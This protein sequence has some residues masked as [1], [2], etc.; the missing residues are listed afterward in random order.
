MWTVDLE[1][2]RYSMPTFN[3]SVSKPI[4]M[5]SSSI[6]SVTCVS[7]SMRVCLEC[8]RPIDYPQ[9][10]IA[11]KKND[12]M[13]N[14]NATF[15]FSLLFGQ[16]YVIIANFSFSLSLSRLLS[17]S[18]LLNLFWTVENILFLLVSILWIRFYFIFS[19]FCTMNTT[20]IEIPLLTTLRIISRVQISKDCVIRTVY[21]W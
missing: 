3:L 16:C 10:K 4:D 18:P 13:L 6:F 2:F 19:S 11:I 7:L 9:Y 8:M 21:I 14:S 17:F 12:Q 5:Y 1:P 20:Q 15:D